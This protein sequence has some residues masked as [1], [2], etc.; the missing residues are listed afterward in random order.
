MSH[1][2]PIR[3]SIVIEWKNQDYA[4]NKRAAFMIKKLVSQWTPIARAGKLGASSVM[5]RCELLFVTDSKMAKAHL[6][7]ILSEQLNDNNNLFDVHLLN[8]HNLTYYQMKHQGAMAATGNMLIFLDSDVIPEEGW[9]DALLNAALEPDVKIVCGNTYIESNGLIG[10]TFAAFWFFPLR[11]ERSDL[12]QNVQCYANNLACS[13]EF[14]RLHPFT[15]IPG[16][17]RGVL[18]VMKRQLEEQGIYMHRC[19]S[20]QVA[21]PAPNGIVHF[22]V[23]AIGRGRNLYFSKK[24]TD[25]ESS[26]T[27][28]DSVKL[29]WSKYLK[30]LRRLKNNH[31][32][33]GLRT[34]Q[35][36]LAFLIVSL[37]YGLST[38][39]FL[40]SNVAPQYMKTH[41]QF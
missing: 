10:K 8:D 37:Y 40:F 3:L 28:S 41:F 19:H 17:N 33:V 14:Y 36:P 25:I 7:D 30:G 9:L 39:G 5:K 15:D 24:T 2:L 4:V 6:S 11:S 16:T 21:H 34:I 22:M 13:N 31:A 1:S 12:E 35:L 20:A 29:Q 32:K 23:R 27:F 18:S 26:G 38:L